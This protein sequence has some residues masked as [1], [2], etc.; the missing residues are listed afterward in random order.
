MTTKKAAVDLDRP[1]EGLL[2]AEEWWVDRYEF[3][4]EKGYM[5]RP[6]YR[7]GWKPSYKRYDNAFNFEDGHYLMNYRIID[8]L[9]ISD[10]SMV[11]IKRVRNTTLEGGIT[12]TSQEEN[13]C[14][15]FSTSEHT[16]Q[17]SNHS[18]PL[19]EVLHVPG[20]EDE[21]LL[22]MPWMREP[23][24]PPFR[25]VGEGLQFIKE[26]L[27]GIQYMHQINVAHRDCSMNNMVMDARKMYPDGHH[28]K[29]PS[30]TY[31]HKKRARHF[32]RTLAPPRYYLIDFGFSQKYETSQERP[33]EYAIRSG[34][35]EPPEY[36]AETPCDP[37]AT[38]VFL[39]G[40]MIRLQFLDGDPE[41]EHSAIHGFESLRPLVNNM[42]QDDPEKRPHMD[43]VLSRFSNIVQSLS[44]WRL[45]SRAV[46]K[47]EFFFMKPF[48]G[49]NHLFWTCSM[50]ARGRPAIPSSTPAQKS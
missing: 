7:P 39:L 22:V 23:E 1:G 49:L 35:T 10:S 5:L 44:Q 41:F 8:A 48:R 11:A 33:P 14:A 43:E 24:D 13:I 31:D 36:K 40:N 25:T 18:I 34:G 17:P 42:I 27:E 15:L 19:L 45:R 6:R 37:F 50:I 16:S 9:K 46:K 4:K 2:P 28:P 12:A 21:N 30:R 26:M 3:L 38:D 47:D 29:K 32:S 20:I